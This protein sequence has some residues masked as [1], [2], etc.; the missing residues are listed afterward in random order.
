MQS[1]HSQQMAN[2]LAKQQ[3]EQVELCETLLH[4]QNELVFEIC[5][6]YLKAFCSSRCR[7]MLAQLMPSCD[8]LVSHGNVSY[9]SSI[10]LVSGLSSKSLSF[11]NA[12]DTLEMSTH[13]SHGKCI[14][15]D[16][17]LERFQTS[18]SGTAEKEQNV[19]G[20]SLNQNSLADE[21][22]GSYDVTAHLQESLV[23]RMC[24]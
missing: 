10:S 16:A 7:E 1:E 14:L 13:D 22:Q 24:Q 21:T 6:M 4:Q 2:L 9:N 8:Y 18:I 19:S 3:K 23:V 20:S 5:E 17:S 15:S 12:A 11:G